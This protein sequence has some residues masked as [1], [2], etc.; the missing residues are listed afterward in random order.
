MFGH[1]DMPDDDDRHVLAAAVA[2][3]ADLLCTWNVKDFPDA[4]LSACRVNLVTPDELLVSLVE[5]HPRAM[6]EA[7]RTTRRRLTDEATLD[8]LRRADGA[9]SAA[10]LAALLS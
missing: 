4:A 7:H 5:R 6:L 3:Q 2:A 10:A 9:A 8:A 1:V